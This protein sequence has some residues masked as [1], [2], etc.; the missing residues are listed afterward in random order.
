MARSGRYRGLSYADRIRFRLE[1]LVTCEF[2]VTRRV[3]LAPPAIGGA[4]S[5][6]NN[7]R[8]RRYWGV[9]SGPAA[10]P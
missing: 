4:S 9:E 10:N 2:P 7:V 8:S 6:T 1:T 5:Y 3:K